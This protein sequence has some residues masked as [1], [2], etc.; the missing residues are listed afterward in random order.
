MIF[1]MHLEKTKDVNSDSNFYIS[2]ITERL[3]TGQEVAECNSLY[4]RNGILLK[5]QTAIKT[6]V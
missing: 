6:E 4:M 5:A 1:K 2:S 3:L